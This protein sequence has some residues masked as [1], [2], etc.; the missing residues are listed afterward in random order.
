MLGRSHLVGLLV[1]TGAACLIGYVLTAPR[2]VSPATV[3][4][5]GVLLYV[6][7]AAFLAGA[8]LRWRGGGGRR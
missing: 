7:I 5:G 2:G 1:V 4:L 8:A 6:G 3:R